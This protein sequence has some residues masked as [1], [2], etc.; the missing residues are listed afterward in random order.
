MPSPNL[1][2]GLI[3]VAGILLLGAA[4]LVVRRRRVATPEATAAA[5]KKWKPTVQHREIPALTEDPPISWTAPDFDQIRP[6]VP[7]LSD[8]ALSSAARAAL[9][10]HALGRAKRILEAPTLLQ[11]AAADAETWPG[12]EATIQR[13]LALAEQR[14]VS[15]DP[16]GRP[17]L[18]QALALCAAQG[19]L[20]A[21]W[22]QLEDGKTRWDGEVA[23]VRASDA[24]A[25]QRLAQAMV[26]KV[27]PELFG[28]VA[29]RSPTF[30]IAFLVPYC[31]A[32]GFTFR[33]HGDPPRAFAA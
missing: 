15:F 23:Q 5:K 7:P 22:R 27:L 9:D 30:E 13:A 12:V 2:L 6:D 33:L 20:L 1:L 24:F 32:Y 29:R 31:I 16:K 19:M 8:L 3:L 18:T 21:E 11:H 17:A 4:V 14:G 26:K 10:G 28:G 25:I